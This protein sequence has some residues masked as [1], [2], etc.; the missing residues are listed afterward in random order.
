MK[1]IK[2][3][4]APTDLSEHSRRGIRFALALA[5][6][7]KAAV[8]ILHVAKPLDDWEFYLDEFAYVA[9]PCWGWPADRVFQKAHLDLTRFLE[10]HID[11]IKRIPAVRKRIALGAP[12][13]EI[14]AV[15]REENA[16]LIVMAP[17]RRGS[18]RHLI[19][20]TVTERVVR[21][22]PCPV[23]SVTSPLPSP[24]WRGRSTP[25]FFSWPRPKPATT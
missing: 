25:V 19:G 6:E 3:V 14:A 8:V 23:L 1:G 2:T 9:H 12:S 5:A 16:E 18:L 13:R 17:R 20:G 10:S 4:L 15:A 7:E 11:Q 21:M 22:S 24:P